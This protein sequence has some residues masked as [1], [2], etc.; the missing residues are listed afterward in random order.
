RALMAGRLL[1]ADASPLFPTLLPG[2][3]VV[4][5]LFRRSRYTVVAVVMLFF[6]LARFNPIVRWAVESFDWLRVGRYPEKFALPM[7]VAL[8]VLAADFHRRVRWRFEWTLVTLIP[9]A[10]FALM[11]A[12]IDRFAPYNLGRVLQPVRVYAPPP[13]GGQELNRYDHRL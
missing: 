10:A 13:P 4:P 2:V 9:L 1:K 3:I 11:S 8:I 5:A 12:P 7:C 6:A